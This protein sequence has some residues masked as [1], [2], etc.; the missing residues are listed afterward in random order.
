LDDAALDFCL[1]AFSALEDG[2]HDPDG[3]LVEV[4]ARLHPLAN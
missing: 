2:R 1:T 4:G 3:R